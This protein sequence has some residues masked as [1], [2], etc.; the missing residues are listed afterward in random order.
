MPDAPAGMSQ[1]IPNGGSGMR[2]VRAFV[3]FA[4]SIAVVLTALQ[5][6]VASAPETPGPMGTGVMADAGGPYHGVMGQPVLI[7]GSASSD[8]DGGRIGRDAF[9]FGA[10]GP[11]PAT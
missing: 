5:A 8:P 2:G 10:G 11:D 1:L 6:A 3:A 9:F 7:D 4:V